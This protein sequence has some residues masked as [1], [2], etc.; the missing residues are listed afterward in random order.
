MRPIDFRALLAQAIDQFVQFGPAR[1]RNFDSSKAWVDP[2]LAN[3]ELD[4]VESGPTRYDLIQH[5]RQ[6]ERI[7]N[8]AAEL[9]RF[10]KHLV[11]FSRGS[12]AA[13]IAPD[14]LQ[15]DIFRG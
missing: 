11:K 9:D 14:A 8:V 7:D 6:R 2:F 5:F 1:R 12:F 15:I 4:D 3:L 13:P 10:G